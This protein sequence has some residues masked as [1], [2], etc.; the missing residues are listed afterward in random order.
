[1]EN[2][3][4]KTSISVDELKQSLN[5]APNDVFI[6]DLMGKDEFSNGHIPGAVNIPVDELENYLAEIP[7][8]K[9]IVV[10]CK[11]GLMKS[12]LALQKLQK[13]GFTNA[14]KVEGGTTEWLRVN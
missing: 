2:Q 4:T 7:S 13:S 11:R 8:G 6:I 12:D 10:A 14:V 3:T 1:M 9:T 5:K